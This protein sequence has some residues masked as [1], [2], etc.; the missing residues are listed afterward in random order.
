MT[1]ITWVSKEHESTINKAICPDFFHIISTLQYLFFLK[2]PTFRK[3]LFFVIGLSI[4]SVFLYMN[5]IRNGYLGFEVY[6]NYDPS[7]DVSQPEIKGNEKLH[8]LTEQEIKEFRERRVN[9]NSTVLP[10]KVNACILVVIDNIDLTAWRPTMRSIE[11]RF[12]FK[13]NYTYVFL[14]AYPYSER[15]KEGVAALTS[16]KIEFGRIPHKQWRIPNFVDL[17][18][19]RKKIK[20]LQEIGVTH[21]SSLEFRFRS[22]YMA[23]YFFQHELTKKYDYYWKIEPKSE[24]SCN[25]F[26][27]EDPFVKMQ[28]SNLSFGFTLSTYE[29]LDTIPSLWSSVG[30][31]SFETELGSGASHKDGGR[32]SQIGSGVSF[33]SEDKGMT[34]NGCHFQ[35]A[36]ELG[37][38]STFQNTHYLEYFDKLDKT[39][40]F[41][42]ERWG[43]GPVKTMYLSKFK[44]LNDI[45]FFD[46]I[47]FN[48][49]P[50]RHCP[51]D[52]GVVSRCFCNA[53]DNQDFKLNSCNKRFLDLLKAR[54]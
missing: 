36:M 48:K 15:F 39:G 16:A 35:T 29:N 53:E 44:S 5:L 49:L 8:T 34:Y 33:I 11:D 37:A 19:A 24:I 45:H 23:G 51:P 41:F 30:K 10:G 4:F 52:D 20:A 32:K 38:F 28:N 22:R 31:I 43:D 26:D 17:P 40:G 46:N 21:G 9:G 3:S 7:P 47:G 12:N 50:Y 18:K 25:L 2:M 6:E 14:S 1:I 13:F 27:N 54:A 42:Y